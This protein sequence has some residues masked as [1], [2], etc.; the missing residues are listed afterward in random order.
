MKDYLSQLFN[1]LTHRSTGSN[2]GNQQS[3][4]R[5]DLS[6]QTEYV[7][8]SIDPKI[9]VVYRYARKLAKPIR[10]TEEY[11]L[12]LSDLIPGEMNIN[13]NS[14]TLDPRIQLFFKNT[15]QM[16]KVFNG[17]QK[18]MGFLSQNSNQKLENVYA[19]LCMNKTERT[20]FGV[21]LKG[22][23]LL[24]EVRQQTVSFSSHRLIEP[25]ATAAE[26]RQG[27]KRCAFDDLLT[28]TNKII[29][30]H[31][32]NYQ[33]LVTQKAALLKTFKSERVDHAFKNSFAFSPNSWVSSHPELLR[34]DQE[35]NDQ[36]L[37]IASPEQHLERVRETLS[38]PED[39]IKV[40]KTSIVLDRLGV[41]LDS[42][43]Q[44]D[45]YKIDLAEVAVDQRPE[46]FSVV[47]KYPIDALKKLLVM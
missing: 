31:N 5:L 42:D 46:H 18:L 47:I 20:T 32:E 30:Q 33:Q 1:E 13:A 8:D 41:K 37:N 12:G 28:R 44:K 3:L 39:Y 11:L 7:V 27:F 23:I 22:Q 17:S 26:A 40:D 38:H 29:L 43:T 25:A 36:K 6:K 35:I 9:R 19:L 4:S 14:V 21:R 16:Q 10:I 45:S 34:L 2:T 15:E 24:R